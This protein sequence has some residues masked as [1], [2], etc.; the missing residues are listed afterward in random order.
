MRWYIH[1]YIFTTAHLLIHSCAKAQPNL[2]VRKSVLEPF[3]VSTRP[4]TNPVLISFLNIKMYCFALG[5]FVQVAL[6]RDILTL[7]FLR[8]EKPWHNVQ[9]LKWTCV[10]CVLPMSPELLLCACRNASTTNLLFCFASVCSCNGVSLLELPCQDK[11]SQSHNISL[12]QNYLDGFSARLQSVLHGDFFLS[13]QKRDIQTCHVCPRESYNVQ[14]L[15]H[16]V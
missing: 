3:W 9:F 16:S 15:L 6:R 12:S 2:D 4:S 13:I 14:S 8:G 7:L 1:I 5:V 10:E 11:P